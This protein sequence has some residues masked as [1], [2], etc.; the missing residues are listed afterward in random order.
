[1]RRVSKPFVPSLLPRKGEFGLG[2]RNWE[3]EYADGRFNFLDRPH[4]QLRHAVI[5]CLISQHAPGEVIDLGCGRG[6]Q[7]AWLRP[8]DVTR[9]I[10]VDASPTALSG[11][12]QSA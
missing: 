4:E 11:L 3:Q 8:Q 1:M 5:A 2:G 9:Y 10:G 7:L 12:P 6:H